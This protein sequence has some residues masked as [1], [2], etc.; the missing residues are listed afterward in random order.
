MNI[1]RVLTTKQ[2]RLPLRTSSKQDVIEEL[3]DLLVSAGLVSDRASALKTVLEREKKMSTGLQNGIAIPH[4]K[5][6]AVQQLVAAVGIKPEGIAFEALDGQPT[7]I[8]V[9]TLSPA[10][11]AGPHIQFL[12]DLSKT[13]GD[14]ATRN[15]LLHAKSEDEVVA[16][17][18]RESP[19]T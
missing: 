3:L 13:L 14:E 2:V 11:K 5:T 10:S 17:L 12:A 8:V 15:V 7:R 9:L 4:G 19:A 1:K 18:T 6:D 16:I